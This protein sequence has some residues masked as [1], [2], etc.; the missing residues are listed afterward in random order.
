M[1]WVIRQKR[2]Y[3]K[4][5]ISIAAVEIS[6]YAQIGDSIRVRLFLSRD[7]Y[8]SQLSYK[9]LKVMVKKIALVLVM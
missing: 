6:P 5:H 8:D 3:Y 1:R 4:L 9:D 2:D 7:W